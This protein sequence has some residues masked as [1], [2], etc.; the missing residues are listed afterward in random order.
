VNNEAP[1]WERITAWILRAGLAL[2]GIGFF[3]KQ[4]WAFGVFCVLSVAIVLTPLI[5]SRSARVMWPV[6]IEIILLTLVLA[7]TL[8]GY[9]FG[10]YDRI[11]SFDKILHFGDSVMIGFIA[12]LVVY[13]VH[14]LRRDRSHRWVDGVLILFMTLGLGALWEIAEFASDQLFGAHSQGSPSMP[15]LPDTMWDLIVDGAGG[16]LAAI[17]GPIYMHVSKRSRARVKAYAEQ[18]DAREDAKKKGARKRRGHGRLAP[19]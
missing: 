9:F 13:V 11:V 4:D 3:I 18:L 7:H 12:F 17:G 2:T 1:R 15:P 16:L 6:E 14:I 10:L 19:A 5:V 8:L